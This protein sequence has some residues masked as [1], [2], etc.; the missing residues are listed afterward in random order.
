MLNEL[1]KI[2]AN[3]YYYIIVSAILSLFMAA[4]AASKILQDLLKSIGLREKTQKPYSERLAKLT[5]S[6][7]KASREVDSVLSELSEVAN[8]R[9]KAVQK[10]GHDLYALAEQEKELKESIRNLE[11]TPLPVAE[12]FAKLIETRE[13]RSAKRDYLLFSAGVVVTT[14]I[15]III[16]QIFSG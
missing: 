1:F 5:E 6:L 3:D 11:K 13:K 15:A 4:L 8:D 14:L 10:L 12:H 9:E 7:N 2:M 16:Q